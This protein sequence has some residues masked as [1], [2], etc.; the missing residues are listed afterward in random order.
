MQV[1]Q[2]ELQDLKSLYHKRL[3][4]L[5]G[6][7]SSAPFPLTATLEIPATEEASAYDVSGFKA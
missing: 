7:G 2:I 5:K 4:L 3:N 1:L 6:K